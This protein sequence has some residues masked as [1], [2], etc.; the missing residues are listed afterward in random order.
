[1]SGQRI[2]DIVPIGMFLALPSMKY[3]N[4][5]LEGSVM[6]VKDPNIAKQ[7]NILIAI[8]NDEVDSAWIKGG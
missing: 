3:G 7:E 4:C 8:G 6:P 1:M 2:Q 5:Q